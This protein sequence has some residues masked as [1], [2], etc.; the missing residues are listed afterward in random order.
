MNWVEG[1]RLTVRFAPRCSERT[2]PRLCR[3]TSAPPSR[4]CY[5]FSSANWPLWRKHLAAPFES[6]LPS[7][8]GLV[9]SP[10]RSS[11]I[12]IEI[13]GESPFFFLRSSCVHIFG[14]PYHHTSENAKIRGGA[15]GV[16]RFSLPFGPFSLRLLCRARMVPAHQN[17]HT[18]NQM[19][20]IIFAHQRCRL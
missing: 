18:N 3:Q 15:R 2:S 19:V 7:S 6:L 20:C 1:G 4:R 14:D 5:C 10:G 13:S 8:S 11:D 16:I 9:I 17:I 12:V